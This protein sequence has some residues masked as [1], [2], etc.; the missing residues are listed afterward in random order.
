MKKGEKTIPELTIY[1]CSGN[2]DCSIE[3]SL[4]PMI[5]AAEQAFQKLK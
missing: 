2:P 4:E 1:M 5:I 3:P